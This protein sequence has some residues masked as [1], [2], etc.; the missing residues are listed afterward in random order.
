MV[1]YDELEAKSYSMS[2]G[3]YFEIKIEYVD[4]SQEDFTSKINDYKNNLSELLKDGESLTN[5]IKSNLEN[6]S[7]GD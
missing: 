7:Y 2:A 6:L 3:Q 1:S 4:I 5:E